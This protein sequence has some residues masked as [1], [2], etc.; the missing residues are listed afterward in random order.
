MWQHID[1]D[2]DNKK[3]GGRE[4]YQVNLNLSLLSHPVQHEVRFIAQTPLGGRH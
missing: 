2:Y 1:I 3:K 4:V